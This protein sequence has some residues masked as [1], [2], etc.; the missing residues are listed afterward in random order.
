[1]TQATGPLLVSH[2]GPVARVTFNRPEAINA[3]NDAQRRAFREAILDLSAD[4][5][6]RVILIDGAGERGFSAG[7][8][9]KEARA[10]ATPI[11]ER[12]RLVPA[13][14]IEVLD[15]VAKPT[16]AAVHGACFGG[17]M[18]VALACDIRMASATARFGLTETRL[19]LIP[20]GGGTQRLAR[21]VGLGP[22]LDLLLTAERIDAARAYELGI[23]TRLSADDEALATDSL[24]LA[25]A[26]AERPPAALAFAKE[27]ASAGFGKDLSSG[28][29][30]EKALFAL[31]M[32]TE[33]R[34][35]AAEAFKDKRKPVFK[36][37]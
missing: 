4:D 34:R 32:G 20:G 13:S 19:G 15:Q 37:R 33:D 22:A 24:A 9:V 30:L 28:L 11:E 31:L 8:D 3:F 35:E 26:I 21:L 7:A 36:G 10:A 27:A 6:V 2:H 14:W 16:I 23:V 29:R 18:E 12:N 17:G 25:A 1:M 5:A